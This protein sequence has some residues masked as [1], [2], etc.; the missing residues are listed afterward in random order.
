MDLLRLNWD[1]TIAYCEQL[2]G[3]IGFAPELIVGISRGGLV[4]ARV[5]SDIL[6]VRNVGVLGISFYRAMGRPSDFPQITQDLDMDI[7]G[8]KVLVVDD[9]ADTGRSLAVAKEHLLRKGAEEVK[10]ATLH[11]K[12][13]SAYKPDYYVAETTAWIVYPWE[14]HETERELKKK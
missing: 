7:R 2:A 8:R 1:A 14:R 4:P 11:Y 3:S 9:V 5:L 6:G 12:P 13:T 10:V